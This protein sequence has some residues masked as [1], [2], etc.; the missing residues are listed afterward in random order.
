MVPSFTSGVMP[1]IT[2]RFRPTGGV[3]SP[4]SMLMVRITPNH[5]GSNCAARRIG[6][7]IGV[8]IRMMAA[9]GRKQP[10][11]SSSTL[12]ASR[13]SQ[14]LTC[15]WPMLSATACVTCSEDIM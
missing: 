10:A 11:T 5:T 2:N 15:S 12:M 1:L 4:S 8:V 7:R 9:G 13:I 6:I 3:I 14:R